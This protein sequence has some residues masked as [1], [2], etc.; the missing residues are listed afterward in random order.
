MSSAVEKEVFETDR[1]PF[2]NEVIAHLSNE[3]SEEEPEIAKP[4]YKT[5]LPSRNN[6]RKEASNR[7]NTNNTVTNNGVQYLLKEKREKV[8]MDF[9]KTLA[10]PKELEQIP[11]FEDFRQ[12]PQNPLFISP[13]QNNSSGNHSVNMRGKGTS[14]V[15]TVG[16]Q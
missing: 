4:R 5:C 6:T 11:Y 9:Y 8:L 10:K 14:T 12:K 7:S 15:G 16:E 1:S 2:T 3:K 13:S